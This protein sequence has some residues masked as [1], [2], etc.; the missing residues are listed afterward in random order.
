M[1]TLT[2]EQQTLVS[3]NLELAY[4]FAERYREAP[5][6]LEHEDAQQ[7][8]LLGLCHAALRFDPEKGRFS[9]FA[10]RQMQIDLKKMVASADALAFYHRVRGQKET[11]RYN[12]LILTDDM[13]YFMYGASDDD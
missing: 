9:T 6:R 4:K 8:A 7:Q 5:V 1:P 3:D 10:W 12:Q 13:D 11:R 2:K